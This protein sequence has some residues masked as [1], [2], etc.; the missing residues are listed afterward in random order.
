MSVLFRTI[1]I[2]ILILT[3]V[4]G[5][6]TDVLLQ[7]IKLYNDIKLTPK[8][9]SKP[10]SA[11]IFYNTDYFKS[12]YTTNISKQIIIKKSDSKNEF[13]FILL[14]FLTV[15]CSIVRFSFIN[16]FKTQFN[17]FLKIKAK[18][19]EE[20]QFVKRIFFSLVFFI[21][22]GYL[23]FLFLINLK[24]ISNNSLSILYFIIALLT[25]YMILKNTILY[26]I[27][28]IF[29]LNK[30]YRTYEYVT[31]DMIT[32]FIVIGLPIFLLQTIA[33]D[34]FR[35]PLLLTLI[36]LFCLLYLFKTFKII[37]NNSN[38][39]LANLFNTIIYF[40]TIEVLPLILFAKFIKINILH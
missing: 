11:K 16:N 31:N 18:E 37:L 12:N 23:V 29:S 32:I 5:Q 25:L 28:K 27:K 3:S 30:L 35:A 21:F 7:N 20:Y 33:I 22:I 1:L 13:L 39:I 40:I 4:K 2:S 24:I 9:V 34:R 15:L 26:V 19:I 6:S 10:D 14:L 8:V 38:L 36:L 17:N